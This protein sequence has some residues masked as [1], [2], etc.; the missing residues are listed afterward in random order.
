MR[1]VQPLGNESLVG[2]RRTFAGPSTSGIAETQEMLDFCAEH[3]IQPEIELIDVAAINDAYERV[4]RSD[5]RYRFVIDA[6]SLSAPG[7]ERQELT[8]SRNVAAES[9]I[10]T[11]RA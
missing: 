4:L 1:C 3:T 5:V 11:P 6:A 2:N 10:R 8:S 7:G 9:L